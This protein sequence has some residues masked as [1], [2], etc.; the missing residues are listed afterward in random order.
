MQVQLSMHFW[1]HKSL[2]SSGLVGRNAQ[3]FDGW[4]NRFSAEVVQDSQQAL[5]ASRRRVHGQEQ[6]WANPIRRQSG[7]FASGTRCQRMPPLVLCPPKYGRLGANSCPNCPRPTLAQV[8]DARLRESWIVNST[9]RRVPVC[10]EKS[11]ESDRD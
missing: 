10:D 4:D 8:V 3:F 7:L 11:R 6:A 5:A 9:I 1:C 2:S